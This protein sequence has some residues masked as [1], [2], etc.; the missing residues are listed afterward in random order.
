MTH[1]HLKL[2]LFPIWL[3]GSLTSAAWAQ[4]SDHRWIAPAPWH[5]PKATFT[6]VKNGD[7]VASPF[8]VQFG[9]SNWGIAPAKHK[10][11]KTGHHHLLIDTDLPIP[12][13]KP[14]PF[15]K[16]Y[17]HF[18]AGQ[19]ETVLDLPAGEHTLRLLLADHEHVPHMI[20]SQKVTVL[21]TGKDEAKQLAI[22]SR[23]P[24]LTFAN[25]N[26]GDIQKHNFKVQFHA[27]GLNIAN[28]LT[29]LTGTGFFQL[30][31]SPKTG[32]SE[33]IAFPS[34]VTET[35]LDLPEGD[36]KLSLNL[37]NNPNNEINPVAS[38]PVS[39]SVRK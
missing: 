35:W 5:D 12:V 9:M 21:V 8:V 36:Y 11:A 28:S 26:D 27:S 33:V 31:V 25:I 39:I 38:K 34:G 29:K 4:S 17:V 23:K 37:V 15:S 22:K 32:S 13:S 3:A 16:N 6:N 7:R 20:F 18:G 24:S 10:H 2:L 14:I 1:R 30:T 19:M